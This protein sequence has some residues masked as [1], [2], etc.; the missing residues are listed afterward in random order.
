MASVFSISGN[1][2]KD[3]NDYVYSV[4]NENDEQSVTNKRKSVIKN[5]IKLNGNGKFTLIAGHRSHYSHCSH[6]SGRSRCS[7]FRSP[8]ELVLGDRTVSKGM[9]GADVDMLAT[10]LNSKGLYDKQK[11]SKLKGMACFDLRMEQ[12]I[13]NLQAKYGIT[14]HGV[15]TRDVL[16]KIL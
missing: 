11:V 10:I 1:D 15:C 7:S 12:C 16:S 5:V 9:Y 4:G 2:V 13:K 6:Y 8:L 14:D 3:T